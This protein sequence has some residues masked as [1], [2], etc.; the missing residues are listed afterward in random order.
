MMRFP[1][2]RIEKFCSDHHIRKLALA[3]R[4]LKDLLAPDGGVCC[5]VEFVQG[6][7]PGYLGLARMERELADILYAV[8]AYL[9]RF[10]AS[11]EEKFRASWSSCRSCGP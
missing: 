8:W 4:E 1:K 3:S 11:A 6:Y 5:L 7:E 2:K 9:P 10:S